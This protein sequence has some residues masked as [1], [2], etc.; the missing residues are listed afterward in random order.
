VYP[1]I[2][3]V[4]SH[5]D[6]LA[7]HLTGL[8]H[9]VVIISKNPNNEEIKVTQDRIREIRTRSVAPI[10]HAIVPPRKQDLLKVM[11]RER[12]DVVHAHHAFTPTALYSINTAKSLGI[13]TVLTN[14]SISIASSSDM[15]WNPMSYILSPLKRYID[16]AD[17]II[18]VSNAAS[19]FIGRFTENKNIIVIP[20]GVEVSKFSQDEYPDPE[21]ISP[22]H[23]K[24]S[25]LFTVGRLSFRKGF[26]LIIEAMPSILKETPDTQLYIAGSGYMMTFLEGLASGLGLTDKIHFL[27]YVPE[28]ALYWLY[29]NSDVFIFPSITAESFGIT[30][31]EAMSAR[32]PVIASKI[33]G[34]PE[35]IEDGK[36]GLLFNPWDSKALAEKTNRVLGDNDY[37]ETLGRNAYESV[38]KRFSWTIISKQIEQ[39]Y[40]DLINEK[41]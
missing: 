6:G 29:R 22:E 18:A 19:E 9:E 17:R 23:V 11:K 27:G 3:G 37:S 1:S 8:G 21:L 36:N 35:I 28:E 31:I 40:L 7:T 30:L 14:H 32:R 13:P 5:I 2:G 4:Q 10:G 38:K 12:F 20:N 33:G 25:V 26:H 16:E 34:V 24:D 41:K 15:L 39:V